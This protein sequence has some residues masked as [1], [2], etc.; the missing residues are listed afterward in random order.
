MLDASECPPTFSVP[1]EM[2]QGIIAG[3]EAALKPGHRS[4]R[5][6]SGFGRARSR[7]PG[8]FTARTSLVGIAASGRTPYVLGAIAAARQHGRR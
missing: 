2:V 7:A 4:Q 6:R 1:Y 3:G 8:D 5:R